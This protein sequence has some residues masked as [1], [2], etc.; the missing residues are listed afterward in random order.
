MARRIARLAHVVSVGLL[1]VAAGL[2]AAIIDPQFAQVTKPHWD[3]EL[4]A[5]LGPAGDGGGERPVTSSATETASPPAAASTPPSAP[6]SD[7]SRWLGWLGGLLGLAIGA[8]IVGWWLQR[9]SARD[10]SPRA[11][12][13]DQR[14]QV[15]AVV[16]QGL[17]EL[18]ADDSDPR[19]AVIGCWL[20]LERVAEQAG[21]AR[22]TAD[23]PGDLVARMLA[24]HRVSRRALD[25]LVTAYRRAR[26]APH[27]IG[28]AAREQARRALEQVHAELSSGPDL[29]SAGLAA[30]AVRGSPSR[31]REGSD[32]SG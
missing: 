15:R 1:F 18:A 5:P 24:E 6:T 11:S 8:G 30:D 23:T 31:A 25:Q 9:R 20:R 14:K 10:A 2:V 13:D 16:A 19:S 7:R 22:R 3:V 12:D 4:I 17:D 29:A 27:D 26:Y 32:E 21:T 28:E